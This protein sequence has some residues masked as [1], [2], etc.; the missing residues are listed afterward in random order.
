MNFLVQNWEYFLVGF[1]ILEKVVKITPCKW[2]D[3]LLDI[4]YK[5]IKESIEKKV[6]KK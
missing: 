6:V 5:T 4:I 2:D 1:M 3:I